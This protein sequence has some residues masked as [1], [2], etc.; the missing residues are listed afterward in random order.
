MVYP[1]ARKMDATLPFA[2]TWMDL[3]GTVLSETSQ[4]EKETPDDFSHLWNKKKKGKINE[5]K[6]K[7]KHMDTENRVVFTRGKG[8]ECELVK[9]G[10]P[11][12]V[13]NGN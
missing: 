12:Y 1:S 4:T 9:A 11:L 13:M 6:N 10:S 8:G 3:E 5:Q 2:T 7:N